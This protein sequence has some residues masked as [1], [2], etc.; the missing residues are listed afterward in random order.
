ML[1]DVTKILTDMQ[2]DEI[3]CLEEYENVNFVDSQKTPGEQP[4]HRRKVSLTIRKC[5][6]DSLLATTEKGRGISGEEKIKW[7]KL[8]ES[9]QD[10]DSVELNSEEV[11]LLKQRI[12]LIFGVVVVGKA[13]ELLDPKAD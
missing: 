13:Y 5:C 6:V 3:R 7:F 9:I 10:N 8:A 2:G 11:T 4:F 12:A 1:I